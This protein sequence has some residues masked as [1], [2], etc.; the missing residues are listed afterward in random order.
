L[1]S[2]HYN[3]LK[4]GDIKVDP[5]STSAVTTSGVY[6]LYNGD[7]VAYTVSGS[8]YFSFDA[9]FGEYYKIGAIKYFCDPVVLGDLYAYYGRDSAD[10][11]CALVSSGTFAYG[12]IND[13]VGFIRIVHSG[14]V[15][16]DVSKFIIECVSNDDISFSGTLW[17]DNEDVVSYGNTPIGYSSSDPL[18][19]RVYNDSSDAKDLMV[20]ADASSN[21]EFVLLSSGIDGPYYGIN[22]FGIK[23]PSSVPLVSFSDTFSYVDLNDMFGTWQHYFGSKAYFYTSDG[24]VSCS[25]VSSDMNGDRLGLSLT[26]GITVALVNEQRFSLDQSFTIEADVKVTSFSFHPYGYHTGQ[27]LMIGFSDSWPLRE[28]LGYT[29]EYI[30]NTNSRAGKSLAAVWVGAKNTNNRD[31]L[32][33]GSTLVD[34][35]YDSYYTRFDDD[36]DNVSIKSSSSLEDISENIFKEDIYQ[37]GT[38]NALWRT[39]KIS[40]NHITHKIRYYIN[41]VFLNEEVFS[42]GPYENVGIFVGYAG[43]GDIT[44]HLR[45]LSVVVDKSLNS[46]VN[47]SLCSSSSFYSSDY[48]PDLAIDGVYGFDQNDRWVS[49]LSPQE[50]D[51]FSILL[52][53]KLNLDGVRVY[54][55]DSTNPILISGSSYTT[56]YSLK[57]LRC[58]FDTGDVRYVYF[59]DP[60]VQGLGGWDFSCLVTSSGTNESVNAVSSIDIT[61]LDMYDRLSGFPSFAVDEIEFYTVSGT[62]VDNNCVYGDDYYGWSNGKYH[63]MYRESTTNSFSIEYDDLYDVSLSEVCEDLVRYVDYDVSSAVF[64]SVNMSFY[65]HYA[66]S[67]F[68]LDREMGNDRRKASL[69]PGYEAWL[70]RYFDERVDLK[71]VYVEILSNSSG[72]EF[73]GKPDMWKVQYLVEGGDPND[74]D[75]WNDIPPIS[76]SYPDADD[77]TVFTQYLVD[78]N[79]GE[80]YTDFINSYGSE[81]TIYLP[82]TVLCQK[83]KHNKVTTIHDFEAVTSSFYVEFDRSY[84]TQAAR[85]VIKDGYTTTSKAAK[86]TGYT[87]TRVSFFSNVASG[88]YTSPIFDVGTKQN[89]ERIHITTDNNDG[90]VSVLYRS[91]STPPEY[92]YDPAFESWEDM[93]EPFAGLG[94]MSHLNDFSMAPL[95]NRIY[96]I[97]HNDDIFLY[98]DVGTR[99]WYNISTEFCK[100]SSGGFYY[101]DVRM[102]NNTVSFGGN[103]YLAART[104]SDGVYNSVMLRYSTVEDEYGYSGWYTYPNQRPYGAVTASMVSDGVRYIY[105][106]TPTGEVISFD[107]DNGIFSTGVRGTLPLYGGISRTN[108]I[109]GYYN[110]KLYVVGGTI[111]YSDSSFTSCDNFDIFDIS[112]GLWS[113]GES[114]PYRMYNTKCLVVSN[115]MY[116][117]CVDAPGFAYIPYLKYY[118]DDGLWSVIETLGYNRANYWLGLS[119]GY[120]KVGDFDRPDNIEILGNYIYSYSELKKDFRRFKVVKENWESGFLADKDDGNWYNNGGIPWIEVFENSELLPQERYIQYKVQM[121]VEEG[122]NSALL[123][124]AVIVKPL[125]LKD[126]LPNQYKNVYV[127]T[128]LDNTFETNKFYTGRL[129]VYD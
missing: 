31:K 40:Y 71:G 105:F 32:Y 1:F 15:D 125:V 127:K 50:G 86:A 46:Y 17:N 21:G 52:G 101:P 36:L 42:K 14:S 122:S 70:W 8:T 54:K 44:F 91:S 74:E 63:N 53:E 113:V 28:C 61:I 115:I 18:V 5:Y 112:S 41:N 80:Y 12:D 85:L 60:S 88:S 33:V 84:R 83:N 39:L 109:P 110:G 106:I 59:S 124:D 78:H 7:A 99:R 117:A 19:V 25:V 97:C 79:D 126:V 30:H 92:K 104:G 103:I 116:I 10:T 94:V 57:E 26:E 49:S 22:D 38:S 56:R 23:Q 81:E 2:N 47:Q 69:Y 98:F 68:L 9:S 29:S 119:S 67:V 64:D 58:D 100:T 13:T 34:Y 82:S 77:Y 111:T 90:I 66:E 107:T 73:S 102:L 96:F 55:P 89:T 27:K 72:Y 62:Q 4:D 118:L 87:F 35:E 51:K 123:S 20:S 95:G 11:V 3:L 75:D 129:R 128:L 37:D 76:V 45:N 114:L 93:G 24:Y 108:F 6:D 120:A 121:S 65:R 16:T 48:G 43:V